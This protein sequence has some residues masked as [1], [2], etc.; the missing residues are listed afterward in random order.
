MRTI[1]VHA[2]RRLILGPGPRSTA[3]V[4]VFFSESSRWEDQGP[5][6]DRET[7]K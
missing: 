7:T 6:Q 3:D 4:V 1:S 5:E 2:T